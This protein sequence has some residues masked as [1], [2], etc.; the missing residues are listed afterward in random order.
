MFVDQ[1]SISVRSGKGG[2]GCVSF[3]REKYVPKG[4]P[5][6]GNGGRG[7]DVILVAN[8]Q[9]HTLLDHRYKREYEAQSGAPGEPSRRSGKSGRDLRIEL[10]VGTVVRDERSGALIADLVE[11]GQEFVVLRGGIGGRGNAEFATATNQAPRRS[12]PGREGGEVQL[13]LE[14]KLIADVGLVGFPN[15]GKSTLISVISAAQ[16]K[17]ANYPFTTLEPNLGIVRYRE[18]DSFTVADLPGL[19]EGAHEGKGLGHQFLQHVERTR[20]L[21]MLIDCMSE[22]Y[23]ADIEVLRNELSSYSNELAVKPWFIALSKTDTADE[24]IRERMD[25]LPSRYDVPV[26]AFSSVSQEGINALKDLMWRMIT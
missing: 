9:L 15:A 24:E 22:D 18:Y 6:G 19:I 26:V 21:A 1:V 13:Q 2:A 25:E 23:P 4:G 17:I 8:G 14:L 5:D 11:N 16:P 20:V 12:E 10:P 7:G 3:R